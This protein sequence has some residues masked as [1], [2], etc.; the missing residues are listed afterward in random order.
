LNKRIS[1]CGG[2][3]KF[4][5]GIEDTIENKIIGK[6]NRKYLRSSDLEIEVYYI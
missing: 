6:A 4:K 3:D 1:I 5:L 2:K